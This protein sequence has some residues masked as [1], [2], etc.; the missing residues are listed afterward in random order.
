MLITLVGLKDN[1]LRFRFLSIHKDL[2]DSEKEF[3]S[4]LSSFVVVFHTQREKQKTEMA[5]LR[6]KNDKLENLCRALHK[7]AKVASSEGDQVLTLIYSALV[8][9]LLFAI[10]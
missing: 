8:S 7:G 3:Q 1:F 4:L 2:N 9:I 5:G 6:A 10:V